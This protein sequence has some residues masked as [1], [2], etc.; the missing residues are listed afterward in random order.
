MLI[1]QISHLTSTRI[2]NQETRNKRERDNRRMRRMTKN[3]PVLTR[4]LWV[5]KEKESEKNIDKDIEKERSVNR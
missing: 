1:N 3:K 2:K 5:G 4:I